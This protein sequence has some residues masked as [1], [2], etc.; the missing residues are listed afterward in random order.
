MR[1]EEPGGGGVRK[2]RKEHP[3]AGMTQQE[4]LRGELEQ[5][6]AGAKAAAAA[7]AGERGDRSAEMTV[8]PPVD[9]NGGGRGVAAGD[10]AA[11]GVSDGVASDGGEQENAAGDDPF[12]I[13]SVRRRMISREEERRAAAARE[14]LV[15]SALASGD[16]SSANDVSETAQQQLKELKAAEVRH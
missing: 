1:L 16:G 9:G 6:L 4:E 2:D 7:G 12:E 13:G 10:D 5:R 3:R 11:E 8:V 14:E 15:A